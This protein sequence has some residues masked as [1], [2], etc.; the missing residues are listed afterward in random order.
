[1]F[2]INRVDRHSVTKIYSIVIFFNLKNVLIKVLWKTLL[3]RRLDI[4]RY[5]LQVLIFKHIQK[6]KST[7]L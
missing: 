5:F 4:R 6:N 7:S 1:M 2:R 3:I